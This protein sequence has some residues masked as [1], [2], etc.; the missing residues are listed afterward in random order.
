VH[1]FV[2]PNPVF[3]EEAEALKRLQEIK[4]LPESP[5]WSNQDPRQISFGL[6][7]PF[8]TTSKSCPN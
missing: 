7:L 5:V 4:K 6:S 3:Y 1:R 2:Q 8:C